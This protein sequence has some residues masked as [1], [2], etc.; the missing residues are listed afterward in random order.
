MTSIPFWS[1]FWL[2]SVIDPLIRKSFTAVIASIHVIFIE[3]AGLEPI[4]LVLSIII[5]WKFQF[6]A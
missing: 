2:K 3:K 6:I 5:A 1:G 4:F